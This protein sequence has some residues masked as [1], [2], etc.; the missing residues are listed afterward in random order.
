MVRVRHI[1]SVDKSFSNISLVEHAINISKPCVPQTA[2]MSGLDVLL[3]KVNCSRNFCFYFCNLYLLPTPFLLHEPSDN[4][5]S[6][7]VNAEYV[8]ILDLGNYFFSGA[9]CLM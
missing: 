2:V 7:L 1:F 9:E 8:I 4:T 6:S 3:L 5:N